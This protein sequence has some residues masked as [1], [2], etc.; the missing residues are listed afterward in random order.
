MQGMGHRKRVT[1]ACNSSVQTHLVSNL[2]FPACVHRFLAESSCLKAPL[3]LLVDRAWAWLI[4]VRDSGLMA[5]V[6]EVWTL[7][8][9]SWQ[10]PWS[11][12]P[13]TEQPSDPVTNEVQ[14]TVF[15]S[16]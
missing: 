3:R 15:L 12:E 6:S 16:K 2:D 11:E 14:F 10:P 13:A 9:A 7:D 4:L 8:A 1:P 5:C